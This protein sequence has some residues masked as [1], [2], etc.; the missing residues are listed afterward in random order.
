MSRGTKARRVRT[1]A[2]LA[3]HVGTYV[4]ASY[5]RSS[6]VVCPRSID[7]LP[8]HPSFVR[9]SIHRGM[10]DRPGV[11]RPCSVRHVVDPSKLSA[12]ILER[13]MLPRSSMFPTP[14]IRWCPNASKPSG[15][16]HQ[17]EVAEAKTTWHEGV[18]ESKGSNKARHSYRI[19]SERKSR[20]SGEVS[21]IP[22]FLHPLLPWFCQGACMLP[23]HCGWHECR[24]KDENVL[25][26]MCTVRTYMARSSTIPRVGYLKEAM[27]RCNLHSNNIVCRLN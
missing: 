5:F 14:T 9:E 4:V 6:R 11:R 15:C 13:S 19:G 2:N 12:N 24:L 25:G 7:R 18:H 22:R 10:Q 20:P 26:C 8:S 27:H 1:K 21:S 16:Q 17:R 23:K 3:S